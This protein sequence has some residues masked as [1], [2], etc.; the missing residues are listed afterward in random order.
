MQYLLTE[1]E[2]K[3]LKAGN[4]PAITAYISALDKHFAERSE[5]IVTFVLNNRHI[6]L[7]ELRQFVFEYDVNHI[8]PVY[9]E[10]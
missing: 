5:A 10:P 1:E 4:Q 7:H 9:I 8:K 6:T 3:A 2:Y